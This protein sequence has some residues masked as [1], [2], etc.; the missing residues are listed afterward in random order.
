M[1][2][3]EARKSFYYKYLIYNQ[4]DTLFFSLLILVHFF[5]ALNKKMYLFI[6]KKKLNLN[7]SI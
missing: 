5:Q 7:P 6:L 4:I 1:E 3:G 2:G